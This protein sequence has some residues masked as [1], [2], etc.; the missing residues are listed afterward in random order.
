MG[1]GYHEN[2][3]EITFNDLAERAASNHAFTWYVE[4][5][6]ELDSAGQKPRI[7]YSPRDGFLV[8]DGS[9]DAPR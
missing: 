1:D 3:R 6:Q 9:K 2:Y 5:Y 7:F 8:Q 4:K